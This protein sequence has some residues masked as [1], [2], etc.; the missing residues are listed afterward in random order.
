MD[1][2]PP[3]KRG[4]AKVGAS[5]MSNPVIKAI[6]AETALLKLAHGKTTVDVAKEMNMSRMTLHKLIKWA[7][8]EGIIQELRLRVQSEIAPLA[9]AAYHKALN[10]D[11]SDITERE[12]KAHQMKLSAAKDI[13]FGTG[14]LLRKPIEKTVEETHS[15]DWYVKQ[16]QNDAI[17][18]SEEE[19]V[20]GLLPPVDSPE[21]RLAES[22]ENA[23]EG[24]GEEGVPEWDLGGDAGGESEGDDAAD[25]DE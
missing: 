21:L 11:P 25:L 19:V 23:I 5:S 24:V 6:R 13:T 1:N 2:K 12:I 18:T 8:E 10:V 7:E 22:P 4:K 9:V 3:V 14:I 16:K 20:E 17:E 15:L